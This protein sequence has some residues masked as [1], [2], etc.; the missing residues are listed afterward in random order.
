MAG[1]AQAPTPAP[2]PLPRLEV[3]AYPADARAQIGPAYAAAVGARDD[4]DAVGRLALV[5]HAWE[6]SEAA[7]AAYAL[8]QSLTPGNEDWWYLGALL[9][10]RRGLH[11]EAARQFREAH[12]RTPG[13]VLIALRLADAL[14]EAGRPD[15]ATPLYETLATRPEAAPAAL[16]GLGR[17]SQLTGQTDA[18]RQAY[19][20]AVALYPDFGAAHY[21]LAQLQRR[22][23]DTVAARASLQ[24]QQQCLACWPMPPDTRRAHL[25]AVR[26]DPAALLQRGVNAAGSAADAAA[27]AAAIRLHE[28]AL[29]R[30]PGLGQAHVNLIELYARTGNLAQAEAQ[31]TSARALPGYAAEAHRAWGWV[32]LRQRRQDEALP[33]F[34]EAVRLTPDNAQAQ[35][36]LAVSHEL[37]GR[38]AEAASAYARAVT[39][40]PTDRDIRFG[41]ARVLLQLNRLDE[42]IAQLRQVLDPVDATT[43][44]SLYALSVALVRQGHVEDGRRHAQRA[45]DLARQ[46]DQQDLAGT[47][48]R[49]IAR[50]PPAP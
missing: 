21:A 17:V 19:E 13:D 42:A 23:G 20:R 7:A 47:I 36:G 49:D 3:D 11:A 1:D 4:A 28:A 25:D 18:A 12:T 6:E 24:R 32:L 5:L 50:L 38:L 35:Y 30:S 37:Q 39:A 33:L 2:P 48:A 26:D 8:A 43:P 9:A 31:F 46:F 34:A 16:Y 44:R 27:A 40:A 29:A 41:H 14:L 15:E 45:L 10:T 22:A